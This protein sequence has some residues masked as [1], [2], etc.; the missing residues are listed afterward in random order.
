MPESGSNCDDSAAVDESRRHMAPLPR[1]TDATGRDDA[2]YDGSTPGTGRTDA[3]APSGPTPDVGMHPRQ[4]LVEALAAAVAG[5]IAV[6]DVELARVAY[7][8]LG[9]LLGSVGA[10]TAGAPILDLSVFR[11]RRET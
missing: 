8:A 7:E 5:G 6:G 4:A 9:R 11:E 1:V 3:R 10:Q 2:N